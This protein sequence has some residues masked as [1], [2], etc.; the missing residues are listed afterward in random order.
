VVRGDSISGGH[1]RSIQISAI[2]ALSHPAILLEYM[3]G[4]PGEFR[5]QHEPG[6]R[7]NRRILERSDNCDKPIWVYNGIVIDV[8]DDLAL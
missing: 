5:R 7:V 4:G 3:L 8:S 2:H 6:D 1:P